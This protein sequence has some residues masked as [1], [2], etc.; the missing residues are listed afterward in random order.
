MVWRGPLE[1]AQ[2]LTQKAQG[3]DHDGTSK[4]IDDGSHAD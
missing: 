4:T 2:Q 1:L 3:T